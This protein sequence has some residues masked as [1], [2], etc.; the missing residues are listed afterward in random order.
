MKELV[1]HGVSAQSSRLS[2]MSLRSVLGT[3][4][5]YKTVTA[6]HKCSQGN[7]PCVTSQNSGG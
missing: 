4:S 3:S 2:H 7:D 1:P 5:V 6:S